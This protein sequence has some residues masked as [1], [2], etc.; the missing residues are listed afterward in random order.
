MLRRPS[1]RSRLNKCSW[2]FRLASFR[3]LRGDLAVFL[4]CALESLFRLCPLLGSDSRTAYAP[5][6]LDG[7]DAPQGALP[8]RP[9]RLAADKHVDRVGVHLGELTQCY[10]AAAV[11]IRLEGYLVYPVT[12]GHTP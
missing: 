9:D 4:D 7:A 6:L 5:E 8:R 2:R 12:C 11:D 1:S 10:P 3:R